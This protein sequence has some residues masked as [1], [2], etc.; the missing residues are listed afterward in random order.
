MT[1]TLA[2]GSLLVAALALGADAGPGWQPDL[3]AALQLARQTDRPIFAV[4]H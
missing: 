1:H 2:A 4:L 3:A